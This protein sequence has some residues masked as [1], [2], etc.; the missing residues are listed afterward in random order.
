[1]P[2]ALCILGMV[3]CVLLMI[4]FGLDLGVG[5]PFRAGMVFDISFIVFA[6]ILS[7]LGW[8]TYREQI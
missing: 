5:M 4:L 8:M 6:A 2:K 1:M 7:F 3:I